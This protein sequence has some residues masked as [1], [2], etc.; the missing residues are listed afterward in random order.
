MSEYRLEITIFEG[1]TLFQNFWYKL[2]PR[3]A[4]LLS[5]NL[6]HRSFSWYKIVGTNF[7]HFVTIHTFDRWTGRGTDRQ[8]DRLL[9]IAIPCLHSCSA[10][11]SSPSRATWAHR[12]APIS[13]STALS[14]TPSYTARPQILGQCTMWH[15]YLLRSFRA[16]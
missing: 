13:I 11:K 1:V 3:Q 14:Q 16:Y 8:T 4:V 5:E 15:A 7:F 6:M 10:L 2:V 9:L 12:M